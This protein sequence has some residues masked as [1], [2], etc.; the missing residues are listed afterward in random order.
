LTAE[1]TGQPAVVLRTVSP[2]TAEPL[3]DVLGFRFPVAHPTILFGDGGTAKSYIALFAAAIL[4][5]RGVRVGYLDWELDAEDHRDRLERLCGPDDM[6]ELRYVRCDRPLVH[7]VDRLRRIVSQHQ[8]GFLICDSAGFACDGPPEA[9]DSALA[10]FRAFRPFHGGGLITAHVN[11]SDQGD[12]RP[13]GSTFWHNSARMTW[14]AKRDTD[15]LSTDT[16]NVGLFNRKHNLG[17][18][19][20]ALGFAITFSDAE[21]TI[22]RTDLASID[23]LA[24]TLPLWQRMRHAVA[25][26]PLTVA[27]IAAELNARVDTVDRTVRKY[28]K[29]FHRIDGQDGVSRVALL[30]RGVA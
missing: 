4:E 8:L 16:L 1:R 6:P 24:K 25:R 13:F 14:Y 2:R 18:Q 15:S 28:Q 29:V 27:A 26:G 5:S 3:H 19:V 20:P 7:E 22:R 23:D 9:A 21:T 11:R 12:Q 30:D 10:F 17:R